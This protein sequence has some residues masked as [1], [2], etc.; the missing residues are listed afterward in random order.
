MFGRWNS[1]TVR[2]R[3]RGNVI[4][5]EKRREE[6]KGKERKGKEKE[7]RDETRKLIMIMI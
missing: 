1:F 5:E 4:K 3:V 6:R 2:G 7:K